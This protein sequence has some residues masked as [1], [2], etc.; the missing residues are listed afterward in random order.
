MI[1]NRLSGTIA[2]QKFLFSTELFGKS[3]FW[4]EDGDGTIYLVKDNNGTPDFT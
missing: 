3:Y 2:G 4:M 1:T